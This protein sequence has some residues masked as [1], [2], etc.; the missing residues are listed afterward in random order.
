MQICAFES[1]LNSVTCPEFIEGICVSA[2][3]HVDRDRKW[4]VG[5]EE[6][7]HQTY[8]TGVL[9]TLKADPDREIRFILRKLWA[10]L[11]KSAAAFEG[12]D[13]PFN[14]SHKYAR[15]R[16]YSTTTSPYLDFE[17]REKL[18]RTGIPCWLNLRN[19]D[20]YI[21]RWGNADY[22]R[23]SLQNIPRDVMKY[24]AGFYMGSD[25]YVW[26]REFIAK[27]PDLAEVLLLFP[28]VSYIILSANTS[29]FLYFF[30]GQ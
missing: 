12:Y 8:G 29:S 16:I 30:K 24:E 5:I 11:E 22:V 28:L 18:E 17:Y 21:H 19:D 9:D 3:E 7:L 1:F 2:C 26:G 4:K 25:S 6:W 27:D 10:D 15:A 13:V 23:E 14:T 20:V